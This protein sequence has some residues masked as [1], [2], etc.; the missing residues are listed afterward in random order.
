ML[1]I[2]WYSTGL[3]T[4]LRQ[5]RDHIRSYAR[6]LN[7]Q[8][9]TRY[10]FVPMYGYNDIWSRLISFSV[11][12]VQLVV[13]TIATFIYIVFECIVIAAW[14]G[15]PVVVVGNIVYQLGGIVW[16]SLQ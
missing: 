4:L 12:L 3:L 13:I 14:V 6:S 9:L 10:L 11:R 5:V 8:I 2:W 1:F 15:L 16:Q 7:L